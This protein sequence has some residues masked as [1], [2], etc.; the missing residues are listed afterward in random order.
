MKEGHDQVVAEME[1]L[2]DQVKV[3]QKRN[4]QLQNDLKSGVSAQRAITEV[5]SRYF[6][7]YS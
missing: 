2:S 1:M 5:H 4:L 6:Q 7:L 3:E